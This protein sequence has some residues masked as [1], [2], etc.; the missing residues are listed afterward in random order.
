MSN[1]FSVGDKVR[2]NTTIDFGK[3]VLEGIVGTVKEVY[4]DSY[5]VSFEE[6]HLVSDFTNYPFMRLYE[7]KLDKVNERTTCKL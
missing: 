3:G 2:V 7:D 1:K 6:V 4:S 5:L